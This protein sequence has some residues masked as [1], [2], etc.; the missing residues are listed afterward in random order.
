VSDR[1]FWKSF[2]LFVYCIVLGAAIFGGLIAVILLAMR[3]FGGV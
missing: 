1:A 2:F 3:I